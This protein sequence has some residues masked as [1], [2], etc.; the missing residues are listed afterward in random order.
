MTERDVSMSAAGVIQFAFYGRTTSPDW[1]VSRAWRYPRGKALIEPH[2][3]VIVAE[4]F[5]IDK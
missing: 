4:F 2:G 1:R 3:G 5:D